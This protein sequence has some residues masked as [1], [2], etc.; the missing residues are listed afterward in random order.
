MEGGEARGEEGRERKGKGGGTSA[1]RP[2]II[3]RKR[4][5]VQSISTD[6]IIG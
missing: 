6:Y 5:W 1:C 3:P 4:L 2:V